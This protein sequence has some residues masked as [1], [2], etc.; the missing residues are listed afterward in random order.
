MVL[1]AAPQL[2][3]H[4]RTT[5]ANRVVV[6]CD[7]RDTGVAEA[8]RSA[9]QSRGRAASITVRD[10][11]AETLGDAARDG[12]TGADAVV[13]VVRE[14]GRGNRL[15]HAV[16]DEAPAG[17]RILAFMA[18]ASPDTTVSARTEARIQTFAD[19]VAAMPGGAKT[20]QRRRAWI[21]VVVVALL[22]AIGVLAWLRLSPVAPAGPPVA[23]HGTLSNSGWI[24]TFHLREEAAEIEY[25]RPTDADFISTGDAGPSLAPGT[26]G[27]RAKMYV[28]LP[29]LRDRVPFLVRY[30]TP[31]GSN[32]GPFDAV[33]DTD[34]EA[35][36]SV[37]H[38]L[39]DIPEWVSCRGKGLRTCYFTALLIF[40]YAL[41]DIRYGVDTDV[42]DQ[43]VRFVPSGTTGIDEKDQL[44]IDFR[45]GV[46][47]MT[48][49]LVFLDGT[50]SERK[51]ITIR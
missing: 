17:A 44:F 29:D 35:V 24:V 31:S 7:E 37:K 5:M 4:G 38:M 32:K 19:H 23:L 39:S 3:H 13:V 22:A 12:A 40:K 45:D 48:V 1:A 42:P 10:A 15:L 6:L 14:G 33:F 8:V 28:V 25:K 50:V 11:A 16:E 41:R 9:L 43:S 34:A 20:P 21:P 46:S 26:D 51:R 18:D 49:E 47:F 2:A 36:S 30:R 27:P